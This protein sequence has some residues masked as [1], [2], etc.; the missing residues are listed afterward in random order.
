MELC[1]PTQVCV[2]LQ[3]RKQVAH[4]DGLHHV[5]HQEEALQGPGAGGGVEDDPLCQA[6]Q[7]LLRQPQVGI[8]LGPAG[9]GGR[10]D[11]DQ[12]IACVWGADGKPAANAAPSLG[13]HSGWPHQGVSLRTWSPGKAGTTR[14]TEESRSSAL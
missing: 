13:L 1:L 2:R 7:L 6:L 8:Q 3:P 12:I 11:G 5:I 14:A 9:G 4:L 10:E